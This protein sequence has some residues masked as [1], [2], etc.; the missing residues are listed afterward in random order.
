MEKRK[1]VTLF[2][3]AGSVVT[4]A[5][6][7]ERCTAR[8]EGDT[9]A[10]LTCRGLASMPVCTPATAPVKVS[11]ASTGAVMHAAPRDAVGRMPRVNGCRISTAFRH[12][13]RGIPMAAGA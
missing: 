4:E 2:F 11:V 6:T 7:F 9:A 13:N 8:S 5:T 10:F 1:R 3:E 12:L